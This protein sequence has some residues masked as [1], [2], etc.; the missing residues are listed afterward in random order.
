MEYKEKKSGVP[1]KKG[2]FNSYGIP[3]QTDLHGVPGQTDPHGVPGQTDPHGVPFSSLP[4]NQN[5]EI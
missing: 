2:L 4:S 3:G 1:S 5:I